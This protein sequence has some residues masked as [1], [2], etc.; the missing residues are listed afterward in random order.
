MCHLESRGR[1]SSQATI[2]AEESL[3]VYCKPVE[4]YNIL[5][6]RALHNVIFFSNLSPQSV[7]DNCV[8]Y[9]GY[10]LQEYPLKKSINS[11]TFVSA[12]LYSKMFALQHRGEAQE[13]V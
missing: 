6:R 11:Y 2:A 13:K 4:L 5:Q 1:P 10:Y 3:S 7:L 8:M 12:I 9:I